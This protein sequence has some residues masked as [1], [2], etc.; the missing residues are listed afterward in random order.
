MSNVQKNINF[1]SF[2]C[3]WSMLGIS[4]QMIGLAVGILLSLRAQTSPEARPPRIG[5][6]GS[7]LG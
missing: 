1:K 4:F 6:D 5:A 7:A 3:V 2:E